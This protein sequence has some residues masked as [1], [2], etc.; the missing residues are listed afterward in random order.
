MDLNEV[1]P[2]VL[3]WIPWIMAVCEIHRHFRHGHM[4]EYLRRSSE[5]DRSGT[6]ITTPAQHPVSYRLLLAFYGVI[7][8]GVPVL[9][10]YVLNTR[11]AG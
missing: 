8:L 9:T 10:V 7:A 2:F 1:A 6:R 4:R 5:D 11:S 3:F